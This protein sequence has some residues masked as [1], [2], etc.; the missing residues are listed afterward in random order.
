MT[1]GLHCRTSFLAAGLLLLAAM[2]T[3][4]AQRFTLIYNFTGS[5]DGGVPGGDLITDRLGNLYGTAGGGAVGCQGRGS[6]GVVFEIDTAGNEIVLYSFTEG[7]DGAIPLPGLTRDAKGSLYGVTTDG[8]SGNCG[9]VF[10]LDTSGTLHVLYNFADYP[11]PQ[12]GLVL[13]ASGNLYGTTQWGGAEGVGTL[14]EIGKS[15]QTSILH[16]FGRK[17]DGAWPNGHLILDK[18]G[19]LYGTTAL[20]GAGVCYYGEGCGTIFKLR[21]IHGGTNKPRI[22]YRFLD[23][24][25]GA[26]PYAGAISDSRGNFYG[27]T[28]AG[29]RRGCNIY[30]PGCGTVFKVNLSGREDILYRFRESKNEGTPQSGLVKDRAGNLYGISEEMIFRIDPSGKETVLHRFGGSDGSQPTGSLVFDHAGNLYGT[31][32]YGGLYGYGVVFRLTP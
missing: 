25:D 17:P 5:V 27:T 2:P 6:C 8:G 12:G 22:I 28:A 10:K 9:T 1:K 16:S 19:N 20:G 31:T 15:G 29:G 32:E 3:P 23:R 21:L 7:P 30:G 4:Q 11:I 24:P 13:D 26:F 18:S 14:Y